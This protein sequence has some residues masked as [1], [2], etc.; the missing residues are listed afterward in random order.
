MYVNV[1][2]YVYR[3][4]GGFTLTFARVANFSKKWDAFFNFLGCG[5]MPF[6]YFD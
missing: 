6:S 5:W 2:G 3:Y 1:C 4:G